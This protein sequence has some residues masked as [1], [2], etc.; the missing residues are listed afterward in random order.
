M[1]RITGCF[2]LV[3]LALSGIG[4]G[5]EQ[6]PALTVTGEA[7]LDVSPDQ[8]VIQLGVVHQATNA[9]SAQSQ[10]N[11]VSSEIISALR[12]L[13]VPETSI[14]TSQ[15]SLRPVYRTRP[16]VSEPPSIVGYEASYQLSVSIDDL[17]RVGKI[18][19]AALQAGS[20]Q[21]LGIQFALKDEA[22]ARQKALQEAVAQAQNKAVAIAAASGVHLVR[23]L[24]IQE[25]TSFNH[26]V[27]MLRMSAMQATAE[28]PVQPG[29]VEITASVTL[30]YQI[31][32]K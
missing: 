15:L 5:E 4:F 2:F 1:Q 31:G 6:I 11:S 32:E 7:R 24:E 25:S 18:V 21:L 26:P 3:C 13:G 19:D 17:Q 23:I 12:T 10:V 28:T 8:A 20:N 27:P 14:Q 9:A 16:Q 29:Q 30:R 22:P